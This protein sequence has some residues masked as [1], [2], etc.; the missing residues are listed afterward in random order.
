MTKNTTFADIALM[1]INIISVVNHQCWNVAS[2]GTGICVKSYN[3]S[4]WF[5][6]KDDDTLNLYFIWAK[7]TSSLNEKISDKSTI[8]KI[9]LTNA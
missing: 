3:D 9:N 6:I 2:Y 8:Y 1:P 7:R 5:I 4:I